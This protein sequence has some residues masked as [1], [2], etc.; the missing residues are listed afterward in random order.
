MINFAMVG[1][2]IPQPRSSVWRAWL[3]NPSHPETPKG[4]EE[5]WR[6]RT[7]LVQVFAHPDEP[8][9]RLSIRRIDGR[10]IV[11]RWD[12]LQR[13]KNDVA[14]SKSLAVEVFPPVDDL[15]N[16]ANMRHLFI[17]PDGAAL[18]C[19]WRKR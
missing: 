16:V 2:E 11:E 9:R 19:V 8:W 18:P 14:G 12:E 1:A 4:L 7:Y 15:V 3:S 5:V 13:I 6:S 10:E 17:V